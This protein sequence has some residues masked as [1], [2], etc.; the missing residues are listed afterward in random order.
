MAAKA[1]AIFDGDDSRLMAA[2][3]RIDKS[4]LAT[5]AKFAKFGIAAARWFAAPAAATVALGLGIRKALDVGGHF[6]DLSAN[7]GIAI[8]DLV[9]LEQEFRNAGKAGED[10]AGVISKMQD[11]LVCGAAN[12]TLE[13]SA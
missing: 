9:V 6:A 8:E 4:L 13:S 3:K 11:V 5:Q 10:V 1:T 2:V 12:D 7:T